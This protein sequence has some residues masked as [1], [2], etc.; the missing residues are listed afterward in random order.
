VLNPPVVKQ[1][2]IFIP[3]NP[4]LLMVIYTGIRAGDFLLKNKRL[5]AIPAAGEHPQAHDPQ[6]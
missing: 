2:T 5:P 6:S 1:H 3:L 4:H